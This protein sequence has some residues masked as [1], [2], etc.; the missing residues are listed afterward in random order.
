MEP[1]L[2]GCR[3]LW[4]CPEA[5]KERAGS[6]LGAGPEAPTLPYPPDEVRFFPSIPASEGFP[7]SGAGRRQLL[8][9]RHPEPS[10]ESLPPATR[11]LAATLPKA[12]AGS[13]SQASNHGSQLCLVTRELTSQPSYL[14]GAGVGSPPHRR[15]PQGSPGQVPREGSLGETSG[16]HP[17][18][19][20]RAEI[21]SSRASL[22]HPSSPALRAPTWLQLSS[23]GPSPLLH[24]LGL[25]SASAQCPLSAHPT[26]CSASQCEGQALVSPP[27]YR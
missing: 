10:C 14:P 24:S 17:Q 23:W 25:P 13:P 7:S 19:T 16:G 1:F 12:P 21:P 5:S 15:I 8:G 22:T 9:K 20:S 26:N 3:R 11:A 18:L 27:L 6:L 4:G 2:R